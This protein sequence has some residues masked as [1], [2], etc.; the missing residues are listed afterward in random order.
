MEEKL[1][2]LAI[3]SL[4]HDIGKIVHRSGF[5][6][7]NHSS[8]GGDWLESECGVSDGSILRSV[9]YHHAGRLVGADVADDDLCWIAYIADNIAA[10]ADRR[11]REEDDAL[12]DEKPFS[13]D[14]RFESI[15]NLLGGK[16]DR[17]TLYFGPRMLA[18]SD[19]I[20]FP[21]ESPADFDESFYNKVL[22]AI[23]ENLK[24]FEFNAEYVNSLLEVLEGNLS[25]IPSSTAGREHR[26]ISLFQ[27]M[28]L[29]A[30]VACCIL[31]HAAAEGVSNFKEAF[32]SNNADEFYAKEFALLYS[33][34]ISGIQKFIYTI[35]SEGALKSLR[36]RSFY[37]EIFME[38]L[39]DTLLAALKLTRANL[40][41]SGGGHMY[42][43]LPNT[44]E[45]K[46]T[47]AE[48]E[49][50]TNAWLRKTF[51]T[52]L[53]AAGAYAACSA[54]ALKNRPEGSYRDMYETISAQLSAKKLQ[55]FGPED[56]R[57]L[58]GLRAE[59]REC[60]ICKKIADVNEKG[61]CPEC[62]GLI[63][64]SRQVQNADFF[65]VLK[66]RGRN[67]LAL[68]ENAFLVG[69]SERE[70][71]AHME[72]DLYIR[73]YS[74]NELYRGSAISTGLWVGDY[75][76]DNEIGNYAKRTVGIERLGVLRMDVDDLGH[77]FT[78]GFAQDGGRYNTVSRT[79]DFSRS[80]SMFFKRDI[81]H[82]LRNP[83]FNKL[84]GRN[85]GEA[86]AVTV[87][88]SGGDD[89]F[90]IG[91]WDDVI[92]AAID[93]RTQ[94][95][96]YTQGKLTISAGIGIYRADFPVHVMARETGDLE[97][98]AKL[99]DAAKDSVV[100]FDA[101]NRYRW[102]DLIDD[103]IGSKFMEIKDFFDNDKEKGSSFLY[104]L[105]SLIREREGEGEKK[106]IG[107]ARWAYLL[108]RMEPGK[109]S[110]NWARY[111]R[112]ADSA[113]RWFG[114]SAESGRFAMALCLYVYS[115]RTEGQ[116]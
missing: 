43:L 61:N 76:A 25:Y 114:D 82:I 63:A 73:A 31:L 70:L 35:H 56:I 108:A 64:F 14:A 77:A 6:G 38:N 94:F 105:L 88:Y 27:H 7:R 15:F 13:R 106:G 74:K 17:P 65:A 78:Q 2:K 4:L 110:E 79:A 54:D 34:D 83:V 100:L 67:G 29:T 40:L 112:F 9:R 8:S 93:V 1:T 103:V 87:I 12:D 37:L 55:R 80:M 66:E 98:Q 23:S 16:R 104:G 81:N 30:A 96:A 90:L 92:E 42:M 57:Y 101:R 11:A 48:F 32:F 44:E 85:P 75:A 52:A 47:I 97:E 28:K 86:R 91:A 18:G 5:D 22:A 19:G 59:G 50:E 53:Y 115:I 51:G 109:D 62:E 69:A 89:L 116:A 39:I 95:L 113:F 111:K 24:G 26:D 58:N 99:A 72:S 21:V 45:A 49:K 3:G 84:T 41:Y 46:R 71:R 36:S 10:G 107:F 60:K 68:G 20:N 33:L 102:D